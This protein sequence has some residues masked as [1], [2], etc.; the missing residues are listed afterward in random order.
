MG[1]KL[2]AGFVEGP[3][4]QHVADLFAMDPTP[5]E[6]EKALGWALTRCDPTD[7]LV[8]ILVLYFSSLDG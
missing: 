7:P 6:L 3:H 8:R 2:L 1:L 5:A 4:S